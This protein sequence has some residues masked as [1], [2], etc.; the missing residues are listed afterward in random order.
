[1]TTDIVDSWFDALIFVLSLLVT[2]LVQLYA[3][4][5]ASRISPTEMR[6]DRFFLCVCTVFS[7]MIFSERTKRTKP[8]TI[9]TNIP[10]TK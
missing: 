4:A 6:V 3:V 5:L 2:V 7:N 9:C 10:N 1:M 8:N